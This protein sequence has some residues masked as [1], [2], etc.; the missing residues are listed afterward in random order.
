M[1]LNSRFDSARLLRI[2]MTLLLA[3]AA[4]L[5]FARWH[6]PIPW[7]IGPLVAT[8]FASMAALP[9]TSSSTFRNAGQWTIGVALGLYFT[10]EVT[11]LM[12]S[13][14]WAVA[15]AVVWTLGLGMVFGVWLHRV[16]SHR[17]PQVPPASMR[18]T[19]YF[20]SAIGG[21][22][23]MTLLSERA[24]ARV[25]LV[26]AAHSVR[27]AVVVLMVPFAMQWAK[28]HF[29]LTALDMT[30]TASRVAEW[31]GILWLVLAT[32]AGAWLMRLAGRPNP[33]FLGPLL[34][35]MLLTMSD[36]HLSAVPVWLA[37]GA[38]LVI[39]ISLGV[40]FSREFLHAA[41]RWLLSAAVG[42]V[43]MIVL[44]GVFAWALAKLTGVH[45]VTLMLATAPGGIAE[46]AITA[47]VL[48]LGVPVVTAFQVCRLVAVLVL[49]EP[50]YRRWE[51]GSSVA[52]TG[53][54]N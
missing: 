48:Q 27:M 17:M 2:G 51:A 24:G 4:A 10:P 49:A 31:P 52:R 30:P 35:A 29:N 25:D 14:W 44:S 41:P 54:K 45:P 22:S 43:V 26:A 39:G 21:A 37:N 50:L 5:V 7:M 46:M 1:K 36:V 38:Q 53:A 33:W 16:H 47:K 19:S 34:A 15:L 23:E 6:V 11:E 8:A 3:W 42:A 40:R 9:T 12:L 28:Q 13:L 20:A 18:A 32:G